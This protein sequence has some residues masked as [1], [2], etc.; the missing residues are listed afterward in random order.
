MKKTMIFAIAAGIMAGCGDNAVDMVKKHTPT[1]FKSMNLATAIETSKICSDILWSDTSGDGLKSVD[2]TCKV[3]QSVLKAEFDKQNA[4][5][6]KAVDEAKARV[7]EKIDR[8]LTLIAEQYELG[9]K[10]ALLNTA[11]K[12][13]KY[14]K[15]FVSKNTYNM[16]V[17][18]DE[19]G[20]SNAV[21]ELK[22]GLK[23]YEKDHI[24]IVLKSVVRDG[25][26][27]LVVYG[28]DPVPVKSREI[29]MK[30]VINTDN[31]IDYKGG[32]VT[33]DGE[34]NKSRGAL[35]MFY[36]RD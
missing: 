18:C 31:S 16:P 1:N 23:S 11:N 9:E 29:S 36:K 10:S 22:Q 12:F 34:T 25:G 13:C 14:E 17:N 4:R 30:F 15:G 5:Y 24:I 7:N 2:V 8:N 33:Q 27:E 6:L 32:S 3:S 28:K 19:D 21:S 35:A 26:E 20:L